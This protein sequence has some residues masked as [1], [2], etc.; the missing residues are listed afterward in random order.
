MMSV[1]EES[2][3]R[4]PV[5][6]SRGGS[7]PRARRSLTAIVALALAVAGVG[8]AVS[9]FRT[10]DRT[11][12]VLSADTP[13]S[14]QIA[15]A[16]EEY[17]HWQV[18][19]VAADGTH[20]TRL[21][22]LPTNQFHP[23]WSPDGTRIAFDAQS[24]D[25]EMQ[26]LV[27]DADGSNVQTLTDGPGW[28]YLPAW[29]PDGDRLAFVSTRD[30]N[31]EIY[32][33]N[34]DGSGQQRLTADPEEDLSP[35]WSPDGTKIGF[36]SNRDGFNQ[37]YV[38]GTDGSGVARLTDVEGFDPSW[39][40]DGARIAFASTT[41]GNP[42]IYSMNSDG[43]NVIRLTHDPSHDWSPTWSP[44]GSMLAFESDRDREVGIYVMNA[45]GTDAHRL[46]DTSAQACCPAWRP[47]TSGTLSPIVPPASSSPSAPA[48]LTRGSPQ[49]DP[50]N[51][52]WVLT[53]P[54]WS[55]LVDPSGPYEPKTL[56]A[57]ASYPIERGGDCAPTTA[58]DAL[59]A[60]GAVAWVIEYRDAQGNDFPP[61]SEAFSLDPSSRANY[62][63]SATHATYMFRFEDQDRD[64]QVHVAFGEQAGQEVRDHMLGSLSSLVVDRCPPAEPPVRVSGFGSVVPDE[65]T[66]GETVTVSGP[67][68]RDE[69]W[70]WSPLDK[71]EV[72]WSTDRI[73]IA[74]E[75]GDKVLLATVDPGTSCDFTAT[76]RIPEVPAGRYLIT[77]LGYHEG[78][79]W[80]GERGITVGR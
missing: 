58:L 25:G 17:G 46:L 31:D 69:N 33:M 77:A 29:S 14:E 67:T 18:F 19:T 28:N 22:D 75:N 68:G 54:G 76:F 63:C 42:E 9:A 52:I 57:I 73:G 34:A 7:E 26:I 70:F 13:S 4:T 11:R 44:D 50:Q 20:K 62:E 30:D 36:Q 5:A 78:F 38:M 23:V 56:F 8:L 41:D 49:F 66:P 60:D 40:P 10:G 61:R 35:S 65:A 2:P 24:D 37:I 45:D 32:V 72:W 3:G 21:T 51:G 43:S 15:F 12:S 74:E 79:G 1:Q 6:T 47:R 53:P 59:P 80:M 39:S 55:F 71:I 27:M 64:F 16:K 48:A